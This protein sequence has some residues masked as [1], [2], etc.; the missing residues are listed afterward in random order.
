MPSPDAAAPDIATTLVLIHRGSMPYVLMVQQPRY[1]H[2]VDPRS[3][4]VAASYVAS[5]Y[6][7]PGGHIE[8]GETA[9]MAARRELQEETG[10]R[11]GDLVE[12]GVYATG[13]HVVAAHYV[14]AAHGTLRS[15]SEGVP[16]WVPLPTA[17]ASHHGA[18]VEWLIQR[19][20]TRR[21]S[22]TGPRAERAR[23]ARAR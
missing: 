7:L 16:H 3:G 21:S 5:D 12:L 9:A 19:A 20:T 4:R 18:Y 2:D 22:G 23:A 15:S 1:V 13:A 14:L 8:H 17:L 10:L 6:A 11:A